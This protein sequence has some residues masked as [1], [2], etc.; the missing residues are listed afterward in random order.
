MS[1]RP[2][3][4][5]IVAVNIWLMDHVEALERGR[6]EEKINASQAARRMGFKVGHFSA[7]KYPWRI[8]GFGADGNFHTVA[9]W[10]SWN[11]KGE[12]ALHDEWDAMSLSARRKLLGIKERE[13]A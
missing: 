7:T 9:T 5:N 10:K 4:A 3:P 8:P 13:Q 2:D 1:E 6:D 11:A 12:R